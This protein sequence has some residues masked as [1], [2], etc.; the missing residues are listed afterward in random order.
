M[1]KFNDYA[2]SISII[3]TAA[4]IGA[5]SYFYKEMVNMK[6]D[7]FLISQ[8][9]SNVVKKLSDLEKGDENKIEAIKNIKNQLTELSSNLEELPNINNINTDIDNILNTLEENKIPIVEYK[10]I[11]NSRV[12]SRNSTKDSEFRRRSKKEIIED[13]EDIINQVR[14]NKI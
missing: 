7:M 4:L 8:T 11:V 5:S 6:K 3:N 14:K 13:D 9:L 2:A 1:D 12:S 10:P